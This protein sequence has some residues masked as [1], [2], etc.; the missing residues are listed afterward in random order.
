MNRQE[1]FDKTINILV[2]AFFNGTLAK[3][4]CSA[5]AVGNLCA[6]GLGGK[7][8]YDR[9]LNNFTS[10]I[11][12]Q[13]TSWVFVFATN[14]ILG[15]RINPEAYHKYNHIK[16][17]IDSTRYKWQEL[18]EIEKAFEENTRIQYFDYDATDQQKI[19][20]DQHNGLMAVVEVLTDIHEV[21]EEKAHEAKLQFFYA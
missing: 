7:I 15:Q 11:N 4:T 14:S 21:S 6:A 13:H 2:Q 17:C 18:A 5:C 9:D 19:M 16:K 1:L 20:Q 10:D 3:G 12:D 8:W